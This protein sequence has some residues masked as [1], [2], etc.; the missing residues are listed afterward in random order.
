MK[1]AKRFVELDKRVHD[2]KNFS[3]GEIEVDQFL[4]QFA[5]K[6]RKAGISKTMILVADLGADVLGQSVSFYTLSHTVINRQSL[7]SALAKK[8][9]RYPVPVMLLG[10]IAVDRGF[11]GQR[12][13]E[14]TLIAALKESL[15]INQ[16]LPSYAVVVDALNV[17]VAE[18]YQQYGFQRL[19]SIEGEIKL[20]LPM[21]TVEQLFGD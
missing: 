2:R 12:F 1:I 18:F 15:K 11:Q 17:G 13:G 16:F 6:H 5:A 14:V 8:L 19:S 4:H 21:Q 9:P 20:F 7:P 3:S 10:Q